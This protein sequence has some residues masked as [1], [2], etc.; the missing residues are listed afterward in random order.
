MA[1][2][3]RGGE[4]HRTESSTDDRGNCAC[5]YSP[6]LSRRFG[7]CTPARQHL[8][9]RPLTRVPHPISQL[10]VRTVFVSHLHPLYST[11]LCVLLPGIHRAL[12]KCEAVGL[13][14]CV[15]EQTIPTQRP[16]E[17]DC[18]TLS[19]STE[20]PDRHRHTLLIAHW[21]L[22]T[23]TPSEIGIGCP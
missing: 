12:S 9:A 14:P 4:I 20:G 2:R 11:V 8:P 5:S 10:A 15:C 1:H 13:R 16:S 17:Q 18:K 21:S 22:H 19:L 6:I 3:K 7:P 23:C